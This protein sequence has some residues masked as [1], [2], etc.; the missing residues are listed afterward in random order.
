MGSCHTDNTIVDT[1]LGIDTGKH[2]SRTQVLM[3]LRQG[4]LTIPQQTVSQI[5]RNHARSGARHGARR[6]AHHTFFDLSCWYI[7]LFF[8]NLSF[9]HMQDR[10]PRNGVTD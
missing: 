8:E 7:P 10:C 6:D 4:R 2:H 1:A 3:L 9:Y 5:P